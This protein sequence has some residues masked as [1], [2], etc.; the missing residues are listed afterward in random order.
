MIKFIRD[1][2]TLIKY[3]SHTK[4]SVRLLKWHMSSRPSAYWYEWHTGQSEPTVVGFQINVHRYS[5]YVGR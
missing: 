3:A 2:A 1:V 4:L 5:L